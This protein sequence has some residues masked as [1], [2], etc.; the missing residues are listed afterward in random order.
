MNNARKNN[1]EAKNDAR[2]NNEARNNAHDALLETPMP[3]E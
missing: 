1:N 2:K 3:P